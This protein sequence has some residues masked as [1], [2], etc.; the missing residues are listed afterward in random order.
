MN[1]TNLLVTISILAGLMAPSAV[2][3][4][5]Q[6]EVDKLI[7]QHGPVIQDFLKTQYDLT[8]QDLKEAG[9]T[10]VTVHRGF[11]WGKGSGPWGTP[12]F[13]K[14]KPEWASAPVGSQV[15]TPATKTLSSFASN[16][17]PHSSAYS[18]FTGGGGSHTIVKTTVP[19]SLVFSYPRSGMGS[20]WQS[21]FIV[22]DSP[23]KWE[24]WKQG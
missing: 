5:D 8:Q 15:D 12:L 3:A 23:G 21:E 1:T 6:A 20:Y 10:H 4:Q 14:E 24:I 19:A 7:A 17:D 13:G 2:W 16:F 22:L 9:I 18:E 11:A